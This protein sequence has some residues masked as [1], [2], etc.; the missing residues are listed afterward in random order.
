M[1]YFHRPPFSSGDFGSPAWTLPLFR[2]LYK[3]GV[4]LYVAGHEHFFAYLPPLSPEGTV[5]QGYGIP[6]LIAGT[7]GA[8]LFPDPRSQRDPANPQSRRSLKWARD[9]ETLVANRFGIVRIDLKPGSFN[10]SFVPLNNLSG[11]PP[12][13]SGGCHANPSSY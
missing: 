13:G 6:G 5:D 2:K 7:G 9:G 3:Y 1:A 11:V 10:W 4:D 8:V 12:S